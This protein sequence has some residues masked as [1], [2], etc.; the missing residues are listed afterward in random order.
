MQSTREI[1][2]QIKVNRKKH[3]A[4]QTGFSDVDYFLDGGFF[5]KELIVI[6][7]HTGAGKSQIA[8]QLFYNIA[9]QGFNCAYFSLEISNEM[10]LSR[11]IGAICNIKPTK[12]RF[13]NLTPDEENAKLRAEADILSIHN[14]VSYYDDVYTL[15]D[16][17][18][19]I[20]KNN[21]DLVIID[22]IQNVF[23]NLPTE[24]TRLS[25][26]ALSLQ[27]LAKKKDC[28]ILALSQLSNS[29]AKEGA[30][31]KILE[32]KGSGAIATV[33]DLGFFLERERLD[34]SQAL[35]T[36][37]HPITLTLKKNRRGTSYEFELF[38]QHPGGRIYG[39]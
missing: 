7:A 17:E 32:Y 35:T 11:M 30:T 1:L 31:S 4:M 13:G 36:K 19:E 12:L 2:D 22:F 21:F 15:E 23:V 3:E 14:G 8:G 34:Y 9:R 24:Y 33:C 20:T 38:Y 29:S 16:I 6:G 26:V 37:V 5:K 25:K 28:C 18:K 27:N 39:K 10:V